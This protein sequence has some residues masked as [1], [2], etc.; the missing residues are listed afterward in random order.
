MIIVIGN[1][2]FDLE[3]KCII[4]VDI[5]VLM[6]YFFNLLSGIGYIDDIDYLGNCCLCFVGELL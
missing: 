6:S 4:L 3:V 2:F 5:I 1:V